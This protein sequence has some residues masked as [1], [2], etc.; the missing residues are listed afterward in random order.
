MNFRWPVEACDR[1]EF[2][3]LVWRC[4]YPRKRP[5]KCVWAP[6]LQPLSLSTATSLTKTLAPGSCST[7]VFWISIWSSAP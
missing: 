4:V 7:A 3:G 2:Q 5:R 1:S 6:D